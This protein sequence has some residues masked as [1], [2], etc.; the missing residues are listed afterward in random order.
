MST[1][2]STPSP[3]CSSNSSASC[4]CRHIRKLRLPIRRANPRKR[5]AAHRHTH[6]NNRLWRSTATQIIPHPPT[7]RDTRLIGRSSPLSINFRSR[8]HTRRFVSSRQIRN[9]QTKSRLPSDASKSIYQDPARFYRASVQRAPPPQ[10][11][12]A[13]RSAPLK[14]SPPPRPAKCAPERAPTAPQSSLRQ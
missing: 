7:N 14:V 11:T 6:G 9:R 10:A 2:N 1:S 13:K 3:K 8:R 5:F 12:S 4:S